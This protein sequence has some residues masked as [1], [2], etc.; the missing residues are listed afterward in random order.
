[1]CKCWLYNPRYRPTFVQIVAELKPYLNSRFEEESYFYSPRNQQEMQ[2]LQKLAQEEGFCDDLHLP[3]TPLTATPLSGSSDIRHSQSYPHEHTELPP[4]INDEVASVA[5]LHTNCN[6]DTLSSAQSASSPALHDH[7]RSQNDNVHPTEEHAMLEMS[8][9]GNDSPHVRYR[10]SDH[11]S[12]SSSRPASAVSSCS[13]SPHSNR[14]PH[15]S[16]HVTRSPEKRDEPVNAWQRQTP[17]RDSHNP[18]LTGTHAKNN[19]GARNG[20]INGHIAPNNMAWQQ[21]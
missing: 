14:T 5:S 1:M 15:P 19:P 3:E 16:P 9:H 20:Y 13:S 2:R 10:P 18:L 6:S 11:H 21:C 17:M 8:A 4:H 12:T 7:Y